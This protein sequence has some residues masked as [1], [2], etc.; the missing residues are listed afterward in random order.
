MDIKKYNQFTIKPILEFNKWDKDVVEKLDDF[1][2]VAV[3]YELC[4]NEDPQEEPPVENYEKASKYAKETT[5]LAVKRKMSYNVKFEMTIEE[6]STFLDEIMEQV[7]DYYYDEED[8]DVYDDI[9]D[10]NLY[11]TY[12]EKF[13]I[14]TLASNV[15][16]FFDSQNMEYLIGRVKEKLPNFYK[17]YNRTFKYELEGD[18]E[19]QRILEFSPKTY[20]AGIKKGVIQLNDFFNEFEKQDY[21]YFNNRTALHFNIGIKKG[22]LNPLKAL[23]LMSDVNRDTK[24]PYTFKGIEH[25]LPNIHVGSM[26]DKLKELLSGKLNRDVHANTRDFE[27]L[28]TYKGY[29]QENIDKLD[30]NNLSELESF[31]NDLLVKTNIDFWVK[32]FGLNIT[33]YKKN[34]VEFRFVGGD[35]KREIVLEKLYYF[36]YL[37]YAMS[38][39][40]YK[41]KEYHKGLYKFIEELKELIK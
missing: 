10:P 5:L 36:S 3:E 14:D 8:E 17:K 22:K 37:T 20:V 19:K 28:D 16:R 40:E 27:K 33:Q 7:L 23:I 12:T 4:A 38:N 25:R 41:Q 24:T 21:W 39:N 29:L 32:E 31:M 34:Y 9:L 1:F 13:V 30:L 26:L 18:N 6:V 11:D 2:T 35:V 15:M